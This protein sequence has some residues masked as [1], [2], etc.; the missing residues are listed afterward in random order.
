M[1]EIIAYI[2]IDNGVREEK[3]FEGC[4]ESWSWMKERKR[5]H[6]NRRK[7]SDRHSVR[8]SA[9]VGCTVTGE[10]YGGLFFF[11]GSHVSPK[12]VALER[13]IHRTIKGETHDNDLLK[14]SGKTREFIRG[15]KASNFAKYFPNSV[16][17]CNLL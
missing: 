14:P 10:V 15:M 11:H 7:R 2:D 4:E 6:A 1:S 17:S 13:A 9:Y 12:T 16:F 3:S 8:A 5:Y